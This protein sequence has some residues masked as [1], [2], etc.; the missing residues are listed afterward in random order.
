M[1]RRT[2]DIISHGHTVATPLEGDE[3][4]CL[5]ARLARPGSARQQLP[6]PL[7]AM[8]TAL[9]TRRTASSEARS[10]QQRASTRPISLA[11]IEQSPYPA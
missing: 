2:T 1:I 8:L 7:M 3:P 5:P 6:E 10:I 11:G 9:A 4:A